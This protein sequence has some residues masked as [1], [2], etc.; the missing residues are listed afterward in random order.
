MSAFED[1][2]KSQLQ[3]VS[4]QIARDRLPGQVTAQ[5]NMLSDP[6][7]NLRRRPGAA[8]VYTLSIPGATDATIRA[9]DTDLAGYKCHIV[10]NTVDGVVRLLDADYA[11]LATLPKSNY[12][13]AVDAN[14]VQ[15][16]TVGDAFFLCNLERKPVLGAAYSGA[17]ADR[18]GFFHVKAGAFSMEYELNITSNG[19]VSTYKTTTP[20]GTHVGDAALANP[21]NLAKLLADL[22]NA[23]TA[24]GVTATRTDQYVYLQSAS[25]ALDVKSGTGSDYMVASGIGYIRDSADLPSY[26]PPEAAG[27]IMST[28]STK[29]PQFFVY[30]TATAAWLE[31]GDP[32]SPLSITNVP[33]SV[34]HNAEG[35]SLNETPFEGRL[36]GDDISNPVPQFV[37]RGITGMSNYQ[38]RLVLLS[39]PYVN[40]SASAKPLRFFRTTVSAIIDSDPIEVGA[41]A[42]SSASYRH[43]VPFGKDLLLFSEK[44]Q[45]LIPG[46]TVA[47]TPRTATVVVTSTYESDMT[48]SPINCGRSIMYSAPR[49]KDFFGLLEMMP[50]M[51]VENQYT[52]YDS[53]QHLPKYMAGRCRFSVASSVASMV[54]FAPTKDRKSLIVHEYTWQGDQKVQQAWH[55]WTFKYNIAA[56]YFSGQTVHVL[57]VN[58][59]VLVACT[60]DP[61]AGSA[62]SEAEQYAKLDMGVFCDVVD[63]NVQYPAWLYNFD[64]A[65]LSTVRMA[66]ATGAMAGEEVGCEATG[67]ILKSAL[68]FPD[69][70]VHLGLPY[71][72][73]FSPTPPMKKD[74]NGVKISTNKM[75][76]L[77]FLLGT[78]GSSEYTATVADRSAG[79]YDVEYM[80]PL[81]YSSTELELDYAR[82]GSDA[83]NVIPA[84]TNADS[85]SL[86]IS[87]DGVGELNVVSLEYVARYNSKIKRAWKG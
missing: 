47:V 45:A 55:K 62:N 84:R 41:S 85:T 8:V 32:T 53:T 69:G 65:A 12:L 10:V 63:R 18:R 34:T 20:D 5:E 28:G 76:V 2:Y 66:V 78:N 39:G 15:G 38:G 59:G 52:S 16:C 48:A 77:R 35:W 17:S 24:L 56:A 36:A 81:S 57:F 23:D 40:L 29:T 14:S 13:V 46:S 68:S 86:V 70:R 74:G 60:I 22:I 82:V 30:D 43:A 27:Y 79:S 37:T 50:S 61:R 11:P 44:Y 51:Q 7:T 54:L 72:S 21:V 3:G 25:A 19:N 49:S 64:P 9:W 75:T 80:G 33:V 67:S 1:S 31:C 71:T 26:L 83:V 58:N 4:Q 42:A 87:A 6:V 73:M